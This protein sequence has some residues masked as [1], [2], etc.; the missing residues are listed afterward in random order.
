MKKEYH[1]KK[2]NATEDYQKLHALSLQAKLIDS[3]THVLDWDRDT[4]MPPLGTQIRSE[5][6]ELLAGLVHQHKTSKPFKE[7]LSKLIDIENDAVKPHARDLPAKQI[8]ALH[9][10]RHDYIRAVKLPEDFVK[11]FAKISSQAIG[12]WSI[13]KQENAF[14]K[15]A[16]YLDRLVAMVR[17]KAELIGYEKHPYD[18]LLE[19]YEPDIT[20][21]QLSTLFDG[22]GKQITTLMRKITAKKQ[23][24]DRLLTGKF[25]LD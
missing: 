3:I 9:R 25:P 17:Q 7:A 8:A 5:Q 13:A 21:A 2:Q 11:A 12:V 23:G 1:M 22:L 16:P 14:H 20:T 6:L 18:V 24:D 15:F 4:Y 10:W 19:D